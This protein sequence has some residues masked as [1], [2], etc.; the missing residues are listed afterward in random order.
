MNLNELVS[1]KPDNCR[2]PH[3]LVAEDTADA[4]N[5]KRKDPLSF[6]TMDQSASLLQKAEQAQSLQEQQH[7]NII[8]E[9]QADQFVSGPGAIE[10][11]VTQSNSPSHHLVQSKQMTH[12]GICLSMINQKIRMSLTNNRSSTKKPGNSLLQSL[13]NSLRKP[14]TKQNSPVRKDLSQLFKK[15][16]EQD[17]APAP[18]LLQQSLNQAKQHLLAS[19]KPKSSL[20]SHKEIDPQHRSQASPALQA[21][22]SAEIPGN[23][24]FSFNQ[25]TAQGSQ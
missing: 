2:Q 5:F 15:E 13:N 7:Y 4:S 18:F 20:T 22:L 21:R 9:L 10:A 14:Q 25:E 16:Q 6:L 11:H 17:T 24:Y 19:P 23:Q 1:I 3:K 8:E 12:K